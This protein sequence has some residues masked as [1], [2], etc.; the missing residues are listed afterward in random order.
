[1]IKDGNIK[2]SIFLKT[3]NLSGKTLQ[4]KYI[5]NKFDINNQDI[6]PAY[7]ATNIVLKDYINTHLP[8]KI[9]IN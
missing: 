3:F 7:Y 4:E 6:V 2:Q 8:Y 9:G 5:E 1:M